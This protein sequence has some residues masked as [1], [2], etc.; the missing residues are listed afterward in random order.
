MAEISGYADKW[1]VSSNETIKFMVSCDGR[2]SAQLVR[3]RQ[4]DVG[5]LGEAFSPVPVDAPCNRT[6]NGRSQSIPIGSLCVVPLERHHL[7][8][9]TSFTLM[10]YIR[11]TTPRKGRQAIIGTWAEHTRTGYG[12]EI[13]DDCSLQLV[14]GN[15]HDAPLVIST[16]VPMTCRWYLIAAAYDAKSGIA[17]LWQEPLKGHEF[18]NEDSCDLHISTS[19]YPNGASGLLTIGAWNLGPS[20]DP[21]AWG[22][23]RF[24]NHFNGCV[25]RPRWA[26]RY[27]SRPELDQLDSN[28]CC[29]DFTNDL[30]AAWD[31]E[32]DISTDDI[33]DTGPNQLN[34][35]TINQPARAVPGHN[36]SGNTTDW[37]TAPQEYGAIHFHDDDLVD[38]AWQMD[39]SFSPSQGMQ[40]GIYCVHLTSGAHSFWIPFVIRPA[41][42]ASGASVALLL[43]TA[44]YG[45]YQNHRAR[46]SSL[47]NERL[48]GRLNVIDAT[49][50]MLIASPEMGL[51]TYDL[52]SDGSG[53]IYASRLRPACNVRPNG[54]LWNFNVD[55][56]IV[57]WLERLGIG[58][59]VL[60]DEDLHRCGGV[61]LSPYRA[62]VTGSHPEYASLQMLDAI[63]GYVRDGG[64]L[65]YLGG[66]GFYWR[67]AYH[68]KKQGVIEIR[69]LEGVRAWDMEPGG[70]HMSFTG[71]RGGLW[72]RIGR[73]PQ[74]IVGVG[75]VGQGFDRSSYFRRTP[76]ASDPR[77]A[78]AFAGID[79]D[80]IGA[81][82]LLQGGAA[83]I[84]IDA[85]DCAL[86]TPSHALVLARSENHSNTY[87]L[88]SEEV[89]VPHGATDGLISPDIRAEIVFYEMPGGGAVFS[90]GSIA[91]AGSLGW[92]NFEND[93]F[94]LTTNVL[95]RFIDEAPFVMPV[96]SRRRHTG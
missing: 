58:Y 48:H 45:A 62:V 40:S 55:L 92:N 73:A 33:S 85:T 18:H 46:F 7:E 11:P 49:D 68:P 43:P 56:L 95:Q 31:F 87:E 61:I 39:F 24:G 81:Y 29:L 5:P 28:P 94:H 37:R 66:N 80:I 59:D 60:T 38:A 32:R 93:I 25:D 2:Y 30:V 74:C 79:N 54:R 23:L 72:R 10:A 19:A 76:S 42:N 71:E 65:M 57:S 67:I 26:R 12:L 20:A 86:G 91:Y 70:S 9:E 41:Y 51:S 44:T 53:V 4:P 21:S 52:H 84:E 35:F 82:G 96:N 63:E 3:L 13:G 78:W 8:L 69:R 27:L 90:V 15:S 50:M 83:G 14:I 1:S 6:Y 88:A 16:G 34:G 64:R 89:L 17:S 36:W 77:I 22:G 75:F 47:A